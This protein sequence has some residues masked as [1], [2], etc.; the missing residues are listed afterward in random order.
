MALAARKLE[1]MLPAT[2]TAP[3]LD[4][5]EFLELCGDFPDCTLEYTADGTVI[6]MPPTDPESSERVAYIV[7]R[8]W[9]WAQQKGSGHV[10][11]PDGGFFFRQGSRR[12]PDA[13]WFEDARWQAAKTSGL[14]FP[15]FAPDFLIEV[16]S[17]Y[18]RPNILREKMEEYMA[19]GVPLAWLTDP[20]ARTVTI[21]RRGSAAEVLAEP[22][23]VKG[24]GAVEGFVLKLDRVF[25]G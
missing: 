10:V 15:V 6:V 5:P 2:F 25:A 16:R 14:R 20:L 23:I 11:G 4:E 13:A 7:T 21:Y 8:L 3:G 22:A 18:D 24:E 17:P 9:N 1:N 19:N 12:S